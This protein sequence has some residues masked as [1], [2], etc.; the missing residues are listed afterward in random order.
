MWSEGSQTEDS[1]RALGAVPQGLSGQQDQVE[2]AR[3]G[4]RP[5]QRES[6]PEKVEDGKPILGKTLDKDVTQSWG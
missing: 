1:L 3:C 4:A 5:V 6:S 2:P